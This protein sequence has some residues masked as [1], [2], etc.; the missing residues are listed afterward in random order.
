MAKGREQSDGPTVPEGCRKMAPTAS[1]RSRGGKGTTASEQVEQ[2]ELFRGQPTARKGSRAT[3]VQAYLHRSTARCDQPRTTTGP[4]PP[5]MTMEEVASETNLRRA[6]EKVASN[7]G[8]PGPDRQTVAVVREHLDALLP[9]LIIELLD[10][11][12]RPGAIRRVWIPK[13][14]GGERGLGIPNVVDRLVQQ[15]VHQVLSPSYEPTF[16]DGSHGFR[17]GRSCQTAIAAA[18]KHVEEGYRWVV[19]IDLEKFFDRVHHQRLL[20]RLEQRVGDRRLIQLIRRML[21][22]QVVMPDGVV[23]SNDEGTPQGGPLSPLLSN[24]VLD[25]LDR[26][27]ARR[28]HRFVRYADDCNIYVRSERAGQRVMASITRFIERRL[29][30]SVNAGKSAVARPNRRHFVGFSL[31]WNA[32][33]ERVE[34][35]LSKRSRDR[36]RAKLRELTPRTW[37]GSFDDC[38]SRVNAYIR[39]WVAFFGICTPLA[40]REIRTIESHLRRRLRALL[41][42]QRGYK[43]HIARWFIRLG[44]RPKTAYLYVYR[45]ATSLWALSRTSATH[46]ALSNA[47]LAKRGLLSLDSMVKAARSNRHRPEQLMLTG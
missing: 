14:G 6:F 42:R 2:L 13:P 32:K 27:L 18:S 26:E 33:A 5:A 17:P 7:R 29:R 8:A 45:G 11:S 16:H 43:R 10:G 15:A 20:A 19:D 36:M 34:V 23:V 44:V 30:L 12:Y 41:L 39:G 3:E 38:L 46:V 25:E 21:K 28:G 31:W 37:G 4:F 22:A 1:E 9:V 47:Y 40:G 35:L 24:I